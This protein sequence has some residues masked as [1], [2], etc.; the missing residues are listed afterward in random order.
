MGQWSVF[1]KL[2]GIPDGTNP[3][4]WQILG[5][6]ISADQH[7]I[8][9]AMQA[10]KKILA[11]VASMLNQLQLHKFEAEVL[12][13]AYIA[14]SE[15]VNTASETPNTSPAPEN[16]DSGDYGLKPIDDVY[17]DDPQ[18]ASPSPVDSDDDDDDIINLVEPSYSYEQFNDLPDTP[19]APAVD[20]VSD[21]DDIIPGL[22]SPD[23]VTEEYIDQDSFLSLPDDYHPEPDEETTGEDDDDDIPF[24]E[25]ALEDIAQPEQSAAALVVPVDDDDDSVPVLEAVPDVEDIPD[26]LLDN[27]TSDHDDLPHVEA[28]EQDDDEVDDEQSSSKNFLVDKMLVYLLAAIPV[29][30]IIIFMSFLFSS[31]DKTADT[32]TPADLVDTD[33]Q[34]VDS[35]DS[36]SA[37][38]AVKKVNKD[39]VFDFGFV[40]QEVPANFSLLL[41]KVAYSFTE[42]EDAI[43]L[44]EDI[45]VTLQAWQLIA[46]N[47]D[48]TSAFETMVES[49][50]YRNN[51]HAAFGIDDIALDNLSELI[52]NTADEIDI[53][54]ELFESEFHSASPARRYRMVEL[55]G[56]SNSSLLRDKLLKNLN[57]KDTDEVSSRTIRSIC[58]WC[59]P[60][61]QYQ[62]LNIVNPAIRDIARRV[63]NNLNTRYPY[64]ELKKS[65]IDRMLPYSFTRRDV[66][67]TLEWWQA[68]LQKVSTAKQR[69]A[70]N[71]KKKPETDL[72]P[73]Q[74][75]SVLL[76]AVWKNSYILNSL[77]RNSIYL[78]P[79]SPDIEI[80]PNRDLPVDQIL[81]DSLKQISNGLLAVIYDLYSD[82]DIAILDDIDVIRFTSQ[83]YDFVDVNYRAQAKVNEILIYCKLMNGEKYDNRKSS[84][85]NKNIDTYLAVRN[86]LYDALKKYASGN[87]VNYAQSPLVFA[88]LDINIDLNFD[89]VSDYDMP[90][91]NNDRPDKP[92]A[93][94]LA[95]LRDN[96]FST[97]LYKEA[98]LASQ[99]I[100]GRDS[101]GLVYLQ[102]GIKALQNRKFGA[103]TAIAI[104]CFK[105]A[106]KWPA[107]RRVLEQ[108]KP[109]LVQIL[110]ESPD[111]ICDSCGNTGYTI[112]PDCEGTIY[113]RCDNCKGDGVITIK[114]EGRKYCPDCGGLGAVICSECEGSGVTRCQKCYDY[115]TDLD[116]F[117]PDDKELIQLQQAVNMASLKINISIR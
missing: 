43:S 30:A 24:L 33:S 111:F 115:I 65:E 86:T 9:L 2:F 41:D 17:Y 93:D 100:D 51:I 48:D 31:D 94:I 101:E 28:V 102:L 84:R 42:E 73:A 66:D 37:N 97:E 40:A 110:I 116:L 57:G 18:P 114:G 55:A 54:D 35:T 76:A 46:S 60:A 107:S 92:L 38:T 25:I 81:A 105:K 74:Y 13:P 117:L 104:D 91:T 108:A 56:V 95:Q 53:P 98:Q 32:S 88:D 4:N 21:D 29:I 6:D 77:L 67:K 58:L 45:V 70:Y 36:S 34:L 85:L 89:L 87:I 106:V 80:S 16:D 52:G 83:E 61:D 26:D 69:P 44:L 11:D 64:G 10:R 75:R 50:D 79:L 78:P 109:T 22:K 99:S 12:L 103:G 71:T 19:P 39:K 23:S 7:D 82:K 14:A 113:V 112:C 90:A 20:P 68:N 15:S 27:L 47:S 72:S 96:P 3:D 49:G 62:L 8:D 63:F 1:F 5:L 59:A